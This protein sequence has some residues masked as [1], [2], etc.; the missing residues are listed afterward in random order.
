[1]Q[2]QFTVEKKSTVETADANDCLLYE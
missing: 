1:L 2:T